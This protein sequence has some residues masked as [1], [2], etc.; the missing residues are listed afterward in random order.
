MTHLLS[1]ASLASPVQ[2]QSSFSTWCT[3]AQALR[4]TR[5]GC[6]KR[7]WVSKVCLKDIENWRAHM[8]RVTLQLRKETWMLYDSLNGETWQKKKKKKEWGLKG[9]HSGRILSWVLY[10]R[11][12]SLMANNISEIKY[13]MGQVASSLWT[14]CFLSPFSLLILCWVIYLPLIP[15]D[16]NLTLPSLSVF[17][18][19]TFSEQSFNDRIWW[20]CEKL[21]FLFKRKR[22]NPHGYSEKLKTHPQKNSKAPL[23]G[24]VFQ[25]IL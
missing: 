16:F 5:K 14:W 18:I 1:A 25:N 21:S 2:S 15:L 3:L 17:N 7:R 8:Q 22:K 13:Q 6:H 19:F 9:L 4:F 11:Y 10:L 20:F 24:T 12:L 23:E